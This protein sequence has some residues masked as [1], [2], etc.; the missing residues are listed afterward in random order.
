[1]KLLRGIGLG[2]LIAFLILSVLIASL[3]AVKLIEHDPLGSTT[4]YFAAF[5]ELLL[6]IV[7]G[8]GELLAYL[9][10]KHSGTDLTFTASQAALNIWTEKEFRDARGLLF[11]RL[12][13]ENFSMDWDKE[14]LE[15][16]ACVCSFMDE[17]AQV[18][19]FLDEKKVFRVWGDPIAKAWV[20]L[21]PYVNQ[22]RKVTGWKGKW[23]AFSKLGPN[24]RRG[25]QNTDKIDAYQKF[26]KESSALK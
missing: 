12:D 9:H 1:M 13:Q 23:P 8:I 5:G 4:E 14:A 3:A 11:K 20:L 16:A 26:I 6:V 2:L 10:L 24:A 18:V 15:A 21:E 17:F 22:E 19:A 25:L 7:L